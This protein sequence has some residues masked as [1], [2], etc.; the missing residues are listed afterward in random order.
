MDSPK[1]PNRFY[2]NHGRRHVRGRDRAES[3]LAGVG[4]GGD[5]AVFDYDEDGDLDVLRL[6][7][8]RAEPA[9]PE[10]RQG[11]LHRRDEGGARQDVLGRDGRRRRSTTTA[12]A[13]ST[14]S[15]STCTPT[16]GWTLDGRP[17][18]D[19]RARR[20]SA[21][22]T[23]RSSRRA[24]VRSR[25]PTRT[26]SS[27][28][29]SHGRGGRLRQH[30]V[31]QPRRRAL[32]GD[33]RPGGRR[34]ALAVGHRGRR[35]RRRRLRG[36][37]HPVGHGLPVLVLAL[38]AADERRRRDASPTA[39]PRRASTRR[40]AG[41]TSDEHD[42]RPARARRARAAPRRPT[43]T[44]TAA[45]T[46]SSTTSTTV[47]ILCMNRSPKRALGRVAPGRAEAATATRSARS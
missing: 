4:W 39:P 6:Q 26:R 36:R 41:R 7:H 25:T 31:P 11:A 45:S 15:S 20:S 17:D 33:V 1:E 27:A 23:A 44:A 43:S 8:V 21:A 37:V 38:A 42:R 29:A 34:D 16:C 24:G 5:I 2:R 46:S 40:R 12:T 19:P 35:L 30:A 47:P 9:L 14:S 22:A 32:R 13:A 28:A 18:D 3:G 10:R